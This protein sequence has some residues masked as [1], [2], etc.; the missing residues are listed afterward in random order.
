MTLSQ[1]GWR[2][3]KRVVATAAAALL[4]GTTLVACSS[5]PGSSEGPASADAIAAAL[6]KG[7]TLNYWTWTPSAE[8]Q[9]AA[10]EKAYPKVDVKLV[11]TA[12]AGDHNLKLQNAITAGTGGP[13]VAQ[14]EYQSIPQFA[15]PGSLAD[16]TDYGFGDLKDMYTPGPW[17]AVA[18]TG[19]IYGLPQDSGPMAM[20][21]NK[22]VFDK[23]DLEVPTT[24]DEYVAGAEKLKA[25]APDKIYANDTGDA[26]LAT[27]LIWQAGGRPFKSEGTD[28]TINLADEGSAKW[29]A[30][31]GKLVSEKLLGDIPG[32]SDEWFTA[33][34]DDTIAT[35]TT[36]AWMPGVFEASAPNG[37]GK[38]RVAPMP[39][40]DGTPANAENGGSAEVVMEAS[41]NK[42]LA[43]GFLKWLN[44]DPE[45]I[46][47]FLASG[48]FPGTVAD[49]Q[50]AEFKGLESE[51]FGGQKIN[52][53]L[54]AGAEAVST[55]WQYLP[56]QSYANSIYSDTAGQ[57]YLNHSDLADGLADWQ[58]AN[59]KY[60]EE[61]G[62]TIK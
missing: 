45:S 4:I 60:G 17:N 3:L 44:S 11:N 58:A 48:G 29:A 16:L 23:Y 21:Y 40:Y 53:V 22:D 46:K 13:D 37:S 10:F 26:G 12:T 15:L 36:G 19:P 38:W 25:A 28:V 8:A 27:S 14:L 7:G 49:L 54:V 61:Q 41:K 52:E 47:I 2:P 57:A 6:E 56:W 18:G 34:S 35:L 30:V 55:G 62:Y 33:L 42:D 9:V 1:H 59:A 39:T 50:S 43:A 5:T 31:W 51:Y 24:W 20:F 32:W